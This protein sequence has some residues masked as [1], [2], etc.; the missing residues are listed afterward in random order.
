MNKPRRTAAT[1][2]AIGADGREAPHRA[3]ALP[4]L[5]H[6]RAR[7]A[8]PIRTAA[9]DP[10]SELAAGDQRQ[11]AER[12]EGVGHQPMDEAEPHDLAPR[13]RPEAPGRVAGARRRRCVRSVAWRARLPTSTASS[14]R[15]EAQDAV[16]PD[17]S[18]GADALA[19]RS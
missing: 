17:A 10:A 18:V 12:R 7:S 13:W 11:N 5:G 19:A 9:L 8:R 4:R 16:G 6:R 14:E 2:S 1:S 15:E 3:V